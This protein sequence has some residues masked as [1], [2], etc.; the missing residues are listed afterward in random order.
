MSAT[1]SSELEYL[2]KTKSAALYISL[3]NHSQVCKG[4]C[5]NIRCI[6]TFNTIVHCQNCL[7]GEDCRIPGCQTT[8]KLMRH[9]E[10]CSSEFSDNSKCLMC[11]LADKYTTELHGRKFKLKATPAAYSERAI[12]ENI[13]PFKVS[14]ANLHVDDGTSSKRDGEFV[15]P[16]GLPKRFRRMSE[17]D[18]DIST[19]ASDKVVE[20]RGRFDSV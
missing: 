18:L 15:V 20:T 13:I 7:Q 5:S 2:G 11:I 16:I 19:Q 10:V 12:T 9:K 3:I 6:T 4:A 17:S 1:I 8:L 14:S